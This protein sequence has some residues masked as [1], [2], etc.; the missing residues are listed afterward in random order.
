MPPVSCLIRN[1]VELAVWRAETLPHL[2][3]EPSSCSLHWT[4]QLFWPTGLFPSR[5]HC[6][7]VPA[8]MC[9]CG[10]SSQCLAECR[11]VT[12]TFEAGWLAASLVRLWHLFW[13]L[14]FISKA[15]ACVRAH[16]FSADTTSAKCTKIIIYHLFRLDVFFW[17]VLLTCIWD[18]HSLF[19]GYTSSLQKK[20]SVLFRNY[21]FF[22]LQRWHLL[23]KNGNLLKRKKNTEE[24]DRKGENSKPQHFLALTLV[25]YIF[26]SFL[27]KNGGTCKVLLTI[28]RHVNS[29]RLIP[30]TG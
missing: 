19:I 29:F 18:D 15:D 21:S 8:S 28:K 10:Q 11:W 26:L 6:W 7:L 9:E 23:F 30:Q 17:P 24:K 3:T 1:S 14:A 5:V 25:I 4:A 16:V 22:F 20:C 13:Y 2:P 27:L 12:R